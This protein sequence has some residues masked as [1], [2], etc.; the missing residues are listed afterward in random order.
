MATTSCSGSESSSRWFGLSAPSW[1]RQAEPTPE[2]FPHPAGRWTP[3]AVV[4]VVCTPCTRQIPSDEGDGRGLPGLAS[5]S[6]ARSYSRLRNGW[7][8][9]VCSPMSWAGS[10]ERAD[11]WQARHPAV[12]V[13]IAVVKKF[14]ED[15]APGLGV[16]M[17]YWGF[18]L[19]L[20]AATGVRLDP[21]FRLPGHQLQHN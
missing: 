20:L 13:P 11:R 17:A 5:Y 6:I 18:F 2:A 9:L 21:R 10:L 4:P 12:A 16:Q 15:N 8:A 1:A 7:R 3:K 19:G 14:T